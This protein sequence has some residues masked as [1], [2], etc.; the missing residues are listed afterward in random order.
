METKDSLLEELIR[1]YTREYKS[2]I[3]NVKLCKYYNNKLFFLK[4]AIATKR[5]LNEAIA[6]SGA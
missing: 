5:L 1:D 2:N 4:Q 3:N 6:S